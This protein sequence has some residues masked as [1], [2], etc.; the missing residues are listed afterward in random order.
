MKQLP[1]PLSIGMF[2]RRHIFGHSN[3]Q[4]CGYVM[5]IKITAR[6]F[7]NFDNTF[8]R[9][10]VGKTKLNEFFK[11]THPDLLADADRQ[12]TSRQTESMQELNS[13]L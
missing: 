12:I 7:A 10:L 9:K 2:P 3:A 6:H 1:N 5:F 11:H 4:F 8:K 13:Y